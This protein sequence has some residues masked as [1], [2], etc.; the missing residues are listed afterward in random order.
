MSEGDTISGIDF[1]YTYSGSDYIDG[2]ITTQFGN[3]VLNAELPIAGKT[4]EVTCVSMGNPHCVTY[5]EETTA[6]TR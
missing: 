2:Y 1:D 6:G 4:L 3:P 5:V